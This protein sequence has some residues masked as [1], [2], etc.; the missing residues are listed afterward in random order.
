MEKIMRKKPWF[1]KNGTGLGIFGVVLVF[2]M[3]AVGC[4]T[5]NDDQPPAA[6]TY[7]VTFETDGSGTIPDQTV[8]EGGLV[9]RPKED[10]KKSGSTFVNWVMAKDGEELWRF[11]AN[12]ITQNT[13]IYAKWVSGDV[14]SYT[15][16]FD[17]GDD[18][19]PKP[20]D[21]KIV[22]NQK[23]AEP[24]NPS[25][26]GYLFNDWNNSDTGNT[27]DFATDKVNKDITLKAQ[28]VQAVTITFKTNGGSAIN[29]IN[30][31]AGSEIYPNSSYR[32]SRDGYI[33]EDW[34][35]DEGLTTSAG[36]RITVTSNITL[37]ANWIST[38]E[39]APYEGVWQSSGSGSSTNYWL[40]DDG[41]AWC[42]EGSFEFYR[43]RWSPE[44]ISGSP[45]AF[46]E[47]KSEFTLDSSTYTKNTTDKKTP[48][49]ATGN[50]LGTWVSGNSSIEL[51]ADGNAVVKDSNS[52]TLKYC[53]EANA[54][55]LLT[56][57]D[58]LVIAS[59]TVSGGNLDGF[60]KPVTDSA[61]AGIWKLTDENDQDYY[62]DMKANGS[63]TFHTLGASVSFSFTVTEDERIGERR[64][65][66]SGNG[67]TLK[68]PDGGNEITLTKVDGVPSDG[69]GARAV[70]P[71]YTVCGK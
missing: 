16:T 33:F 14:Q 6:K 55:Y 18:G 12:K 64:Y 36:S 60:S 56:P 26:A 53:V 29:P 17:V 20:P 21:Q 63:G 70:T 30:V 57:N 61:L 7:T 71:A 8:E 58:N 2:G 27:W 25:K 23:V 9:G 59:I 5:G 45:V 41:T 13:T 40:Q 19:S 48:A 22:E 34:Y 68:F 44:Q 39:L 47:A 28:W 67:K 52:V 11:D 62:W 43:T 35:T 3:M 65:E 32:P 31:P 49:G 66:V 42:F 46:N 1:F 24:A 54:V 51:T 69:S 4:P 37:Y 50:L 10:P 38:S 15:V